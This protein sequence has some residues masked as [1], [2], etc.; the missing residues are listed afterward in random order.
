MSVAYYNGSKVGKVS[1]RTFVVSHNFFTK[2]WI[3]VERN[4]IFLNKMC[5]EH[6][7]SL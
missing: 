3:F 1:Q 6:P 2:L 4:F 7:N 5:Q